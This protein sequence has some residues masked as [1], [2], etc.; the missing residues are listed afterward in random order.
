MQMEQLRKMGQSPSQQNQQKV[1]ALPPKW[2]N[3]PRWWQD[4]YIRVLLSVVVLLMA[5]TTI[6]VVVAVAGEM[7]S[8]RA[9]L[10]SIK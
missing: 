10:Q 4:R 2:W 5:I 1:N 6:A 3:E 8:T 9:I 7:E